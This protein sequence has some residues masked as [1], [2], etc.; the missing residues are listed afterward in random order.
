M[1]ETHWIG[2]SPCS[3]KTT[4]ATLLAHTHHLP[5]YSCDDT[6]TRHATT[7]NPTLHKLATIDTATRLAQPLDVQVNDV[8]RAYHEQFPHILADLTHPHIVEGAALLPELLAAHHVPPRH[9]TW[10]VPTEAFQRHHYATRPWATA[11]L[12]HLPHP[13]QAFDTWMRRDTAFA[14]I[15]TTQAHDL[16][17]PVI[18]V[19]GT[20]PPAHLAATIA[21]SHR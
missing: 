12:A 11:L 4:V 13:A 19:D 7:T 5:R 6:F 9:A 21:A 2:G 10:L 14:T 15:V 18:V 8:I 3:G 17:Y 20:V 16:G 1:N